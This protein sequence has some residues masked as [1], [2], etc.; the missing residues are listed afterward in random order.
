MAH[1]I[2]RFELQGVIGEGAMGTVYR[3]YDPTI[4]RTVAIKLVK[5]DRDAS[6]ELRD[7]VLREARSAGSLAHPNVVTIYDVGVEQNLAF[8]AME[9]VD[10]SSLAT[11]IEA[12]APFP[13]A[14]I[15]GWLEQIADALDHAHRRGV[16]HRDVKPS[17]ILLSG[18]G[19]IKV[20]DFGIAKFAR[21]ITAEKGMVVGTPGYMAPEQVQGLLVDYRCDIFALGVVTYELLAGKCPFEGDTLVSTI[22]KVIS[23]PPPPLQEFVAELPDIFNGVLAKALEKS[24]AARYG[25]C[26]ELAAAVREAAQVTVVPLVRAAATERAPAAQLGERF[27]R[28]C[29]AALEPNVRF[30][31]RCGAPRDA[32]SEA[33]T[34]QPEGFKTRVDPTTTRVSSERGDVTAPIWPDTAPIVRGLTDPVDVDTE[35]LEEADGE[36][37]RRQAAMPLVDGSQPSGIAHPSPRQSPRTSRAAIAFVVALSLLVV[38]ALGAWAVMVYRDRQSAP[39]QPPVARADGGPSDAPVGAEAPPGRNGGLESVAGSAVLVLREETAN[40]VD[41]ELASGAPDGRFARLGPGGS[42]ALALPGGR[43]LRDGGGLEPD[44]RV[45][46]DPGSSGPYEIYARTPAGRFIRIDRVRVFG[47]H[48]MAHHGVVEADAFKIVNTGT[49]DLLIDAIVPLRELEAR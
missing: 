41:A 46:G 39:E 49:A 3:A 2:G 43:V 21:T 26:A 35:P 40:V 27:C 48:D 45:A 28:R 47:S 20:A 9:I 34:D 14:A 42:L 36:P 33:R 4:G 10:G 6:Q 37:T 18:D 25:S 19:R 30:C 8:I 32:L 12:S 24:A 5:F 15:V 13:P 16:I 29:G 38:G 31:Y 7:R 1:T 17:N 23:E 22:Y 44:V 11:Q